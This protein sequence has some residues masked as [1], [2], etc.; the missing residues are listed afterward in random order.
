MARPVAWSERHAFRILIQKMRPIQQARM[1]RMNEDRRACAI[2]V[3]NA[4]S[5]FSASG[6][7]I[8]FPLP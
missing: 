7:I 1:I 8:G 3:R 2:F 6:N 5:R 4:R